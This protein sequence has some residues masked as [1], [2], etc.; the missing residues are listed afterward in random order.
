MERGKYIRTAESNAKNRQSNLGQMR[1]AEVRVN[2]RAAALRRWAN[3][4]HREHMCQVHRARTDKSWLKASAAG[5]LPAATA[6][7]S[8]TMTAENRRRWADPE[9]KER[10]L[11][12]IWASLKAQPN[13]AERHLGEMLG[14][15]WEYVGSGELIIDGKCPDFQSLVNSTQLIELFGDYWHAGENPQERIAFF[16]QRGYETAILWEH[17]LRR[18]IK[19]A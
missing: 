13:K 7:R 14:P 6:K 10:V 19:W 4:D 15:E 16:R 9:Y 12:A 1:A 2:M 3:P 5:H 17:D 11:R 8:A 18:L